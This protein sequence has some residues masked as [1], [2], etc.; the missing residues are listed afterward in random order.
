MPSATTGSAAPAHSFDQDVDD[1]LRDLPIDRDKP[2]ENHY[3][4]QIKDVDEE[5]KVRKKRAPN[6][7]LDDNLLLS[8]NGLP[9]LRRIAKSKLKFRGKGHECSDIGRLLN[10]YQL[11][12]DDLYP[13][14]K[15]KDALAMVEKLGHSK[16]MQ[17]T[18]KA[19]I[20]ATKP[21]RRD[22]S[23]ER[24]EEYAMS[25]ALDGP[26]A[27]NDRQVECGFDSFGDK[28]DHLSEHQQQIQ[29]GDVPNEAELDDMIRENYISN[30]A[31]NGHWGRSFL[32]ND[33]TSDDELD[34]LLAENT[35]AGKGALVKRRDP[36]QDDP[37]DAEDD[38]DALLAEQSY[39]TA[40]N[41]ANRA[42]LGTE[43]RTC[44]DFADDEEAMAGLGGEW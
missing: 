26:P 25:G 28:D 40:P 39:V 43:S 31:S 32:H 14:A 9:R 37:S 4:P 19:W 41:A 34:A 42:D 22:D 12:L 8:S 15:F 16:R 10:T 21:N 30:H 36:L 29:S 7:K 33:E 13:K 44:D 18:R 17:V 5:I 11:W 24:R 1:F 6:P 3:V 27:G 35:E 20:D 23:P 38:L 2:A